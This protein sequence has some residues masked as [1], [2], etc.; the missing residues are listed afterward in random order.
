MNIAI[1]LC[2]YNFR[3]YRLYHTGIEDGQQVKIKIHPAT[4]SVHSPHATRKGTQS[5]TMHCL[6]K[7]TD[8]VSKYNPLTCNLLGITFASHCN[9]VQYF[10]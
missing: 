6:D 4:S 1:N 10:S 7:V 9:D 2:Q 5:F 3:V 8:E